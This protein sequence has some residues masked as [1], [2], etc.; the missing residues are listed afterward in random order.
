MV[1]N[2]YSL[3]ELETIFNNFINDFNLERST[4]TIWLYPKD[5]RFDYLPS[6]G[7]KLHISATII[8]CIDIAKIV[9][10][11]F[12]EYNIPYKIIS[13]IEELLMLNRGLYG[14]SQIG[15]FITV[16]PEEPEM[17]I[18]L[19][20][21]LDQRTKVFSG[22][23][24]PSDKPCFP[25][26]LIFYRY[27]E[28]RGNEE[29]RKIPNNH[30]VM[31]NGSLVEDTRSSGLAVPDW[32]INPFEKYEE[33]S[34]DQLPKN[35]VVIEVLRK[36]GK[37][38]VYR[39][40]DLS[41][42]DKKVKILKEGL[43]QGEVEVTGTDARTRLQWEVKLLDKLSK[44][45]NIFPQV[46]ETFYMNDNFYVVM[47]D[48]GHKS[49]KQLVKEN[50]NF[51]IKDIL[52]L[53]ITITEQLVKLH[54]DGIILRDLSLDNIVLNDKGECFIIDLE[55]AYKKT[56]GPP[57]IAVGTPGFCPKR[58][59]SL[60]QT[61]VPPDLSHDIYAIGA[62]IHILIMPS[63]YMEFLELSLDSV[64]DKK[65]ILEA[66]N[67]GVLPPFIPSKLKNLISKSTSED[68]EYRYHNTETFLSDL[69]DIRK[70]LV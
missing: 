34:I 48:K 50:K 16:Y 60:K 62:M 51:E 31:P 70:E 57:L 43:F 41:T 65:I 3:L 47:E 42:D 56:E 8:N 24:I 46:Y 12:H 35:Y 33:N 5:I 53:M 44:S 19:S 2:E 67:R 63:K 9:L 15:K 55:F 4:D 58:I 64:I 66:W 61:V 23:K 20:T 69:I 52:N 59:Y 36:R 38:G 7:F 21:I 11:Y 6:Q 37:G 10:P 32:V 1:M 14:Y 17:A 54:A 49:L 18:N 39:V 29:N 30:L 25:Q 13:S 68:H 27:G 45:S 22:P 26:S 40:I 28:I